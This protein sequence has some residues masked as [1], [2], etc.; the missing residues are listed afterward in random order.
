F[1]DYTNKFEKNLITSEIITLDL[2]KSDVI[3]FVLEDGT[4]ITARPSGTEPKLKYYYGVD[5]K[6]EIA[7][8]EKL[9]ETIKNFEAFIDCN[10]K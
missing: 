4:H 10:C 5:G 1:R 7:A 2:P 8:N 9:A 6:T 3:Q